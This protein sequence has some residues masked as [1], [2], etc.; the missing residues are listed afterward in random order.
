MPAGPVSRPWRSYLRF[1]MRGLIVLVLVIGAELGWIVHQARQAH[2]QRDAVAAIQKAGGSVYYDWEWSNGNVIPEGKPWAPQFL[3]DFIG[4]DYFGHISSATIDGE[5][6]AVIAEIERLIRLQRLVFIGSSVSDAGLAH[7]KGLN[8]LSTLYLD[9]GQV[10][11][12]GLEHLKGLTK[13]RMLCFARNR[14]TEAESA[15][16]REAFPKVTRIVVRVKE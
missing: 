6:D 11:D 9:N 3:V 13:L 5:T 14:I 10:T 4:I 7:L 16:I 15:K 2:V 12:A 8:N 1:S